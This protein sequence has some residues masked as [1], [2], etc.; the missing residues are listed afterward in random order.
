MRDEMHRK[1]TA[2]LR[3]A[4][5]WES[6][7]FPRHFGPPGPPA[8]GHPCWLRPAVPVAT[9]APHGARLRQPGAPG[10]PHGLRHPAPRAPGAPHCS[11]HEVT[12][13]AGEFF[14]VLLAR[15]LLA[16][17]CDALPIGFEPVA[18]AVGRVYKPSRESFAPEPPA[19]FQSAARRRR[20]PAGWK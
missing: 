7:Y 15:C 16:R 18:R 8:Q 3:C 20:A 2:R 5:F 1:A 10:A 9:G 17:V 12:W 11:R 6:R 13:A 14:R 4:K 19:R